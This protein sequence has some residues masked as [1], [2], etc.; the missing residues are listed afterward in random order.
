MITWTRKAKW[1]LALAGVGVVLKALACTMAGTP[2]MVG[3][4]ATRLC[5][6]SRTDSRKKHL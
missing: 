3:G 5:V 1:M 6:G 4:Q 2:A